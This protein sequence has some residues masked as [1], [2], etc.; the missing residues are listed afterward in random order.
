MKAYRRIRNMT[1]SIPNPETGWKYVLSKK[2]RPT[3]THKFPI[4]TTS[5]TQ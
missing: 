2:A 4:R 1:P 3:P 5:V